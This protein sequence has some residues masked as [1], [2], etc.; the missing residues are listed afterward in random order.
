MD[1]LKALSTLNLWPDNYN[2]GLIDEIATSIRLYGF[3]RVPGVWTGDE[4]RAGN[5]AVQALRK[6][7]AEGPMPGLDSQWPPERVTVDES[8]EWHIPYMDITHL[9]EQQAAEWAIIDNEIA[10]RS[11]TDHAKMFELIERLQGNQPF[12]QTLG[13]DR[14]DLEKL[15]RLAELQRATSTSSDAEKKAH[16]AEAAQHEWGV[17]LGDV[18]LIE[19]RHGG[20]HRLVCGDSRDAGAWAR[21]CVTP[22]QIAFTS[23]P[24]AEQRAST[25]G[26]VPADQ[27][28]DWWEAIQANVRAHLVEG[29]S[30]FVNIKPHTEDGERVLYVFDLV[31][32]MRRRWG[33]AFTDEF[34]WR[35]HTAP[36]RWSNR[37]KNGFE[38]VYQFTK[39]GHG[40]KFTPERG[41][42]QSAAVMQSAKANG[43]AR[44]TSTNGTYYNL[45]EVT[46]AG[47]ALPDNVVEAFGVETGLGHSAMFPVGL[48]AFFIGIFTDPGDVVIEP[49]T[50]S[51]TTM[52]AAE[53]AGRLCYG[54]EL[55]PEYCAIIL[56]RMADM[57]LKVERQS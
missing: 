36:G 24:Y 26:G 54:M 21:L 56:Q 31:L 16:P 48:P 25:Y 46:K 30:F 38:P 37:L 51:G 13:F 18:W 23:P 55:M 6:V 40:G 47:L 50:G 49:F 15:S 10:R 35:R 41:G 45:S 9:S 5:H 32:A 29:G 11:R 8:G 17:A 44:D 1:S 28:V 43:G 19:S 53:D 22:G 27:Y 57:G 12:M 4:V 33:W 3:L 20:Y 34:C 42:Y 2:V 7:K 14:K 52:V 39:A